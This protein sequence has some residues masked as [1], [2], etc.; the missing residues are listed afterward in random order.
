MKKCPSVFS[1]T[2]I[3]MTKMKRE[4]L[5][6][7]IKIYTIYIFSFLI[8]M[9]GTNRIAILIKRIL[10]FINDS[11]TFFVKILYKRFLF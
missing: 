6:L 8:Y 9:R 7:I 1:Y 11:S 2:G 5:R 4:R 3:M 10:I